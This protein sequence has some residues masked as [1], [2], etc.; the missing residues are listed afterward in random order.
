M[1][2]TPSLRQ[3]QD[4]RRAQLID[5]TITTIAEHGLSSVTVQKVAQ[6]ASLAPSMVNFHFTS[7]QALLTATLEYVAGEFH[8]ACETAVA[9]AGQDPAAAIDGLIDVCFDDVISYPDKV[10][11]WYAFW[12]ET[13]ARME[14]QAI[15]GRSDTAFHDAIETLFEQIGHDTGRRIN[16]PAAALGLAGL[17]DALWQQILIDGE[18]FDRAA[19]QATCHAYVDNLFGSGHSGKPATDGVH[20]QHDDGLP[21]EMPRTLPA[22]T[23][24][25]EDFFAHEVATI[26]RPAWQ[27]VCHVSEIAEVGAY[28]AFEA[29]GEKAFVIRGEDGEVRAFH[30]VCRHRAHALVEGRGTCDGLIRCPYHAWGYGLAGDLKAIAAKKTFPL[31]D[32]GKFGLRSLDCEIYMGFVYLRFESGGPPVAERYA[33]LAEELESYRFE[34]MV[35][36]GELWE[37]VV[38]A[39]WKNV[40]DNYLEDYHFPT[41]HPGLFSLMSMNYDRE[42]DDAS[43]TARLSHTM[44]DKVKGSWSTRAYASSLPDFGHLPDDLKRRW[45]YFFMYPSVSFDVYP[46]MMDFFHTVPLGPGRTKI[47]WRPFALPERSR[48]HDASIYLN[49][50]V[51]MNV[52]EEDRTLIESVQKGLS[53]SGYDR[54]VLSEKE[55]IVSA[56]H[57]WVGEDMAEAIDAGV[58]GGT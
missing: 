21:A 35:P 4:A 41:G 46:E 34:D 31:F 1:L 19:A 40:W 42:P 5:A 26:H 6:K 39:D 56:L 57:R 15:C 49:K 12:S 33:P 25:S 22:W 45:S 2:D 30:N 17:V 29:F 7:K 16:V 9:N 11:V 10:A 28:A 48:A 38:E 36:V 14:Y 47:R 27:L 32:N 44:R 18:G 43:R 54:G 51:N 50:R 58:D 53:T 23:Y 55:V 3:S 13:R 24:R 37:D 52:H 8:E 20:D